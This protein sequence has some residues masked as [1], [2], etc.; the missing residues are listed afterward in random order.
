MQPHPQGQFFLTFVFKFNDQSFSLLPIFWSTT[1]LTSLL[2]RVRFLRTPYS[3]PFCLKERDW[4]ILLLVTFF[5]FSFI[6]NSLLVQE[7]DLLR[8]SEKIWEKQSKVNNKERGNKYSQIAAIYP[9]SFI[10]H[11]L[12]INIYLFTIISF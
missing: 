7:F 6:S 1:R 3:W 8:F 12:I 2:R 5:F 10:Y 9:I 4:R 11:Y